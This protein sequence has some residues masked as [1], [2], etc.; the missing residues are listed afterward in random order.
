MVRAQEKWSLEKCIGYALENNLQIK[1]QVVSAEQSG[2]DYLQSK[3]SLLPT[4]DFSTSQSFNWGRSVN[5]QD[6]QIIENKLT[7]GTS[8]SFSSSVTVFNG[9]ANINGVKS[10]LIARNIEST[11]VEKLKN[12]ISIS[13]AQAYLQVL[14]SM[15][16]RDS[17]R[18]SIESLNSQEARTKI[19]VNA[20]SQPYSDLLD[21]QSQL[22]SE[23]VELVS[24]EN[25]VTNNKLAL[26]QLLDLSPG[27]NF[28]IEVPD[29]GI[30]QDYIPDNAEDVYQEALRLPQIR[31]AQFSLDKSKVDLSI[32]KGSRLPTLS[33]SAGYGTYFSDAREGAFLE[34]YK[35]DRNPS[36]GISLSIPIFEGGRYSTNV[37]NAK[38]SVKSYEIALQSEKQNLL[39][40]IQKA[41]TDADGYY[42][43]YVAAKANVTSMEESFRLVE[44]KFNVGALNSTD[45]IVA[46]TNLYKA[47]SN[48]S[49][50]KFQYIFQLKIL[51]FYKGKA[52]TL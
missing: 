51:D 4:L 35:D 43:Q 26:E 9:L 21:I 50:M 23:K 5:L 16:I 44:Q 52:L 37:K 30:P 3:L 14:L 38:L 33:I 7:M 32:A 46:R 47:K 8:S 24:S 45:Y 41:I 19:L 15:E 2:N 18:Q 22:A 40:D 31:S 20:G 10:N 49:Q 48:L 25:Q 13:I 11:N 6:L 34:Q 36:V 28:D 27:D 39:K 12:D 42:H 29:L 1:Q 17:Y